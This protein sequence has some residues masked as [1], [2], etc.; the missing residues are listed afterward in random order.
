MDRIYELL[1]L[2]QEHGLVLLKREYEAYCAAVLRNLLRDE[3][4]VEEVL[5]DLWIQVW[6]S[7]P[8]V[9]PENWK[10]WLAR[11]VRNLAI[12]RL[13]REKAS[14]SAA[15]PMLLDELSEIL[16]DRRQGN[17]E[18]AVVLKAALNG[19]LGELKREERQIFLRRY[20][21]GESAGEIAREFSTTEN[22][23]NVMLHRLRKRLRRRLEREGVFL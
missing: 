5:S 3:A 7:V 12:D 10:A 8:P 23:V 4:L 1:S 2:R 21:F 14:G 13:R 18:D 6:N 11:C 17:M 15:V 16:P 20:W 22:R 9:H 19:F